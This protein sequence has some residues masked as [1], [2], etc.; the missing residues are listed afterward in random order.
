MNA[1]LKPD[2]CVIGGGSGGLTVAAAMAA[3]GQS[4]VLI[5]KGKMGGDCL[6]YGCVPSKA[7]IAAGKR[8]KMIHGASSFGI[9]TDDPK[10]SF[11]KVYDHV[12]S[13]IAAIAPHDSVERFRGLGVN[14]IEDAA[15]FIAR[16]RVE[17]GGNIIQARRFVIAT[18]SSAAIPPIEGLDKVS[19]LTNETIFDL[20]ERPNH[21]I[22]IGAGPIG[23]ELAQAYC[24]LGVKVSVIE[25]FK[26]LSK[27]DP[28]VA[29]I[30]LDQIR[31]DGVNLYEDT[32]VVQIN[33]TVSGVEVTIQQDGN[34]TTLEGSH[35]L[36]AAGRAPNVDN[37][38]LNEAGID[39][40]KRGIKVN[41]GLK[42]SN[43]R[44]YAIGDV[45][46]G[47][48]FTHVAGYHASLVV[49]NILSRMPIRENRTIIPWATYTDP[50]L[51]HVGL[52]EAQ[53]REQN[54]TIRILRW[55]FHEN[56]RAQAE[57]TTK[58][59]VKVIADKK[60]RILG[61]TMAGPQAG[62]LIALW[63]LAISKKLTVRDLTGF[64]AAYPTFSETAKRV[65]VE[66]YK[67]SLTNP[68]LR[69]MISFLKWFG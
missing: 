15:V 46:G 44:V 33:K 25:A 7:L 67:P 41:K 55:P 12:H 5:E 3:M 18:G 45:I 53:A 65:A 31:D 62:E 29:D 32:P 63:A 36:I 68:W 69:R 23:I 66:F 34:K 26:A 38:G 61:C 2:V 48:Q 1:V 14:V 59:L 49:R 60:G 27:D 58:G 52:T 56:D 43:R 50:E 54:L 13:V 39:F 37:L 19:Y 42:T 4:V 17:A 64:V 8:A 11:A 57:R 9:L 51:A 47:L 35:L 20:N 40:D 21:L 10:I 22:V 28:E 24:R 16:D 30:V 6:N